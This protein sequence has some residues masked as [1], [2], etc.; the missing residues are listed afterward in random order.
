MK[1][2]KGS[3]RTERVELQRHS[4]LLNKTGMAVLMGA[5]GLALVVGARFLAPAYVPLALGLMGLGVVSAFFTVGP[6]YA[7][8]CPHCGKK[9]VYKH[10]YGAR[11]FR[12]R[13]CRG[14]VA[15][16]K[17]GDRLEFEKA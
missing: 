16:R 7:G 17:Q 3:D 15:L 10:A 6:T 1:A 5:V 11:G 9:I 14:R 13:T 8:V 12:C 2:R 4:G